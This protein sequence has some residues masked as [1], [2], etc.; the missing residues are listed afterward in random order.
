MK[1]IGLILWF[2]LLTAVSFGQP[3]GNE[4]IQYGQKHYR[5]PIFEDGVYRITYQNFV[6]AGIP[7]SL[8]DPQ[9]IQ[10]FAFAQEVPIF[11]SDGQDGVFNSGDYVEFIGEKNDGRREAGLYNAPQDQGNPDYSLF[12]DTVRYYLTVTPGGNHLRFSNA[13]DQ[14]FDAYAPVPYVWKQSKLVFSNRYFDQPQLLDQPPSNQPN[15]R[16]SLSEFIAGEGWLSNP[17][18]LS[19]TA[20]T[21]NVPTAN[22]YTGSDVPPAEA[23][24]VVVGVSDM[25]DTGNDHFIQVKYGAEQALVVNYQYN[26]YRI[27]TFDFNIPNASL[28]ATQTPILHQVVNALGITRDDQAIAKTEITYPHSTNLA[29]ADFF[30]FQY[31]LNTAQSKTRFDFSNIL[32]ANPRIYTLGTNAQRVALS[33]NGASY[34]GLIANNFDLEKFDCLLVTDATVKSISGIETTGNNGFFTNFGQTQIDS[35]FVIIT[36]SSLMVP[37]QQYANYRQQKFNTILVNVDEL[38]DQFGFGVE[39]SG[40]S[41]RN[42]ANYILQTWSSTPQHLLLLG[43]DIRTASIGSLAGTR[44]SPVHFANSLVPSLGFPPSDNYLTQGLANT[45]LEPA[46]RT[47]RVSAKSPEEV[48][49][50]LDKLQTFESQPPAIWMKNVMH[51]GGGGNIAEQ[52]RFANHLASYETAIED[53]SFGGVVTTF[54]KSGSDPIQINVSEEV[55][56]LIENEGVSLMTFFAHA[57]SEGFDQSIDNPQN[58]DWNG[59]YP[60]LLGNGCYSGDYHSPGAGSTSEKYTILNQQGVIGFLA[61]VELGIEGDLHAFSSAFYKHVSKLSYAQ[62]IGSQIRNSLSDVAAPTVLRRYL[63][64]D[65][66]LQGDPGV[67]LNSFPWPDFEITAQD[68]FFTPQEI[69]ADIDS[70]TVKVAVKNIGRATNQP[71]AVTLEHHTPEGIGDSVYVYQMNG[72]YN[73]DTASFRLPVDLQY[74]VGLHQFN[75]FVDL[76][77]NV[78]R[79]LDGFEQVNNQV[80]GKELFISNG[81]LIPI[82]PYPFAVIPQKDPVL[83]AST[84]NPLAEE[85]TYRIEI[86]TTDLFNSPLLQTTEIVETGGVI[87]WQPTLNYPDSIVYFWRCAE[88]TDTETLWRE[89]S[90]QYIPEKLG[91]GQAQIF[92][93]KNNNFFLTEFN[94]TER[95]VDFYSGTVNLRNRVIGNSFALSNNIVLNNTEVEY[96]ACGTSPSVHLAVFDPI[97]FE[98][99]GTNYDGANP[100]HNFGNANNGGACRARVEYYFIYRQSSATQMQALADLLLSETI[101]DG[102]YVVLYT[103]R[104]VNYEL[105][106][107]TPDIYTAFQSLGATMIGAESAQDS[108]PFSLILRKGDPS[109]V[110][111]QYGDTINEVLLNS[112]NIP[113]SGSEGT[114]TTQKIGPS[115]NWKTASWN[116]FSLDANEGDNSQ[117]KIIGIDA[118]GLETD[119]PGGEFSADDDEIDLSNLVSADQ[120]PYLRLSA[121]H[122][123]PQN[124]TPL[125]INRWHVLYDQ[126]PEAAVDPNHF[127]VFQNKELQQGQAGYIAVAIANVSDH[128]MDSLL[129]NYWIED[130]DRNQVEIPYP[131]QDSLRKGEVLIDTV[132]FDTR[133]LTGNNTLWVE[134][135]PRGDSGL[136]DQPEQSH[137]NNLLQIP[138][139]VSRD[140]QNPLLDVTFDGIHIINGEIVSPSPEVLIVLK[141]ENPFL[142]MDE[143]SDT[144]L[145]KVFISSPGGQLV[146]QYFNSSTDNILEFI[147]AINSK[148]RAKIFYRPKLKDD[149][150]YSLLI[151]AT[152]KSGNQSANID[153]QIEFEVVNES[154][155][156]EVL[157]YPNPFSTSTQFVFTLTG[158]EV[159][160]EFKIQIMTI[161]GKIVREIMQQEFGPIRIGR[162]FSEYRWDGRDEYGD[163]LANGVYLYRVIARLNGENIDKRENAASQYFTKSWGK[164]VLFK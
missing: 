154:T 158:T 55:S 61:S 25:S 38:Y 117:I 2:A 63:C 105:W 48:E 45:F 147:P 110:Y 112:V 126:V 70:F 66:G 51:L 82:Y 121:H 119:I 30:R 108:V 161:S 124:L 140:N 122:E 94:R 74:G 137:F 125:Q 69:T 118:N 91:W 96:G 109:F 50:Y 130:G 106:D 160:D 101:P 67:V 145:F 14:N 3:F 39:K 129:V 35:A 44:R 92:Q 64:Y 162:N 164:M 60:F 62:T 71:F 152:D 136:Y 90:F 42:F 116:T 84:G 156:S 72:L 41:I 127:Y 49:W 34:R 52:N 7:V 65:M 75:V 155:I 79:E 115:K 141:D 40:M 4:W 88:L 33:A 76:P 134:V 37:A 36:H 46:M 138:F 12:N 139:S 95:R 1:K 86:D 87:E 150:K 78:I 102:H 77:E 10:M 153:Y 80:I 20:F 8:I 16:L 97:T 159:P 104:N 98:A 111:E 57:G 6:A 15:F 56:N 135:N 114:M 144:A 54:L 21:A 103:I 19:S 17:I 83:R 32:G 133:N 146:Q 9:N 100:D 29:E 28:G 5:I 151:Q 43:K 31:R 53:S 22:A 26:G 59:K 123:D 81:G 157:N 89:S 24:T 13:N 142:I 11:V 18:T 132:Y 68:V 131:R 128:D 73:R 85:R 47:G 27:N 120:Y 163:R 99:W 149:G 148:N 107:N 23:T 93:F 58:F 113:S 143:P